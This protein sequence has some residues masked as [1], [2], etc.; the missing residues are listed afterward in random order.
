MAKKEAKNNKKSILMFAR[1]VLL[2][3]LAFGNLFI[4]YKLFTPLT[5][6]LSF[7]ILSL[8]Y[9]SATIVQSTI[10][11]SGTII[12]LIPACIAGSAYYLLVIL[13]LTT[14]MGFK[15]RLKSLVFLILT[16]C[17]VNVLRIVVFSTLAP[18]RFQYF[19]ITHLLFWYVGSTI[20]LVTIWFINVKIFKIKGIPVYSDIKHIISSIRK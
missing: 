14:P 9:P 12:S 16:F 20:L 3:I 6:K 13:N 11:F 7:F 15:T 19:N 5:V 1:Y 2:L 10:T 18:N 8:I 17:L 4:F